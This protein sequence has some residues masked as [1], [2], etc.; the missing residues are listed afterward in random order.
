MKEAGSANW[1][2]TRHM[3]RSD[4]AVRRYW[5]ERIDNSKFQRHDGSGRLRATADRE[6]S[7]SA[8]RFKT[9]GSSLLR[10]PKRQALLFFKL[11]L[12]F[13]FPSGFPDLLKLQGQS[14]SPPLTLSHWWAQMSPSLTLNLLEP[15]EE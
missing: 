8:S 10:F 11:F 9:Q 4:V 3:G 6:D 1:R 7:W 14:I 5:Q 12:S 2:I 15:I 13:S